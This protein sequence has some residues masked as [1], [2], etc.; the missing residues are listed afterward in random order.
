MY[1]LRDSGNLCIMKW[2]AE[3]FEGCFWSHS[4]SSVSDKE[5]RFISDSNVGKL[6]VWYKTDY[7]A[8]QKKERQ[9]LGLS[10]WKHVGVIYCAVEYFMISVFKRILK[11]Y[12]LDRFIGRC[13]RE[14]LT[15]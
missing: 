9:C 4:G 1:I 12:I 14:T 2:Y 3:W 5:K 10:K 6:C 13:L 15:H 7:G 8:G 11:E